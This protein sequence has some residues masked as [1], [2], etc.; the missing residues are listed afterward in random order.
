ML[1]IARSKMLA[2]LSDG[3]INVESSMPRQ[4]ASKTKLRLSLLSL[5]SLRSQSSIYY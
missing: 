2:G 5:S 1:Y 4:L 3:Q